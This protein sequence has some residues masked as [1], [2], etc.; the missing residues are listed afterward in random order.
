MKA[1]L[2]DQPGDAHQLHIGE[3]ET[4]QAKERELLVKVHS[5]A[6]NR[7]DILQRE[8]KYPVPKTA[9]PILG[10]EMAGIVE[11]VG[12][13]V[14]K[15]KEGDKVFGLMYGG[16]YA[17]YCVINEDMAMHLPEGLSF[18]EGAAIPEAWCTAYQALHWIGKI[19]KGDNVLIH[20][21]ASGVGLAA[22]QLAKQA[23]AGKIFV[24][25][26][27]SDK[28]DFCQTLGADILINYK[29]ESFKEKILSSTDQHGVEIIVDFIGA[30][31]WN[32]NVEILA[33]DGRM[34]MLAFM[35]GV[36]VENFNIA[37]L[38][39]KRLRIEGSTLRSRSDEYQINLFKDISNNVIPK[40]ANHE[41]KIVVDKEFSWRNIVEAHQYMEA[42]K[43][44]GKIVVNID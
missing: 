20:A 30:N 9:S 13:K 41:L 36:Q 42:N 4:P 24:T 33:T 27:S 34:I 25:A 28:L 18:Q 19:Q 26:G 10:V 23:G 1:V 44:T 31:Y 16:A 8:G 3:A 11:R 39:R 40:F 6:L 12:A 38:L 22:I 35:S 2:F 29:T 21:G 5:F 17:E 15:F 37:P 14:S 43:N 32:D 7:M